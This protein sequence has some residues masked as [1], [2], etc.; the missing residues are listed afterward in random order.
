MSLLED[1][2]AGDLPVV[3]Q[4]QENRVEVVK[5]IVAAW[6]RAGVAIDCELCGHPDWSLVSTD[7]CDGI[8]FPLRRAEVVDASRFF[9]AYA[10]ECKK[11]G[12]LRMMTKA[13]VEEL[14]AD[15]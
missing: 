9:L 6:E 12:N 5:R 10:V 13:R 14:A 4:R 3:D 7:D 2:V 8:G 15:D 1:D 11:C